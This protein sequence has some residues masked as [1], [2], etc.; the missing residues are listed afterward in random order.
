MEAEELFPI[1]GRILRGEGF[2]EELAHTG[3]PFPASR[4]EGDIVSAGMR[5]LDGAVEVEAPTSGSNRAI[6]QIYESLKALPATK[7]ESLA[8]SILNVFVPLVVTISLLTFV[9]WWGLS[10][11]L[12]QAAFNA[13][14]VTIVAC[15]CGLGL[16]IPLAVRRGNFILWTLGVTPLTGDFL[17]RLCAVDTVA[18]DK[19]GTLT[20]SRLQL[21]S[22]E[23]EPGAPSEL[24]AWL[25][26]IQQQSTHPVAR[27]FWHLAPAADL[28]TLQIETIPGRGI[29]CRFS[30]GAKEQ[31][32]AIGNRELCREL[33]LPLPDKE[34]EN[35]SKRELYVIFKGAIVATALLDEQNR[36]TT[37]DSLQA[38]RRSGLRVTLLTGD[39]TI[40]S[41]LQ[42]WFD[43]AY[44]GL[45]P[46]AKEA[47]IEA[48]QNAGSTVLYVGDQMN[49]VPALRAA[50]AAI[51]LRS[52]GP[53]APNAAHAVLNH[54]D[55]TVL[56]ETIELARRIQRKLRILLN[57]VLV[58]NGIGIGLAVLGLIHPIV[59][60]LLMLASS[61]TVLSFALR[62]SEGGQTEDAKPEAPLQQ[63]PMIQ[64]RE[65]TP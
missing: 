49:D 55:L 35:G 10:G 36:D 65:A 30:A 62:G 7:A 5:L 27:P 51:G 19:T 4:S 22:L 46:S 42:S 25:T 34:R 21:T 50:N 61:S 20:H 48:W 12:W 6:D 38:L 24:E 39:D 44:V 13:L 54:D 17:Q 23:T 9:S 1:D 2:V 37:V 11:D 53:L 64:H 40:P 29:R 58:Y 28:E 59:A 31:S 56:P 14:A 3:E 41:D 45:T 33:D 43:E 47:Q 16:A 57:F 32:L 18:L 60:A 63:E 8:Q 52:G 26:T 15:P